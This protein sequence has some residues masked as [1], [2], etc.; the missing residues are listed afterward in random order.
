MRYLLTLLSITVILSCSHS[1]NEITKI[2]FARSG[3]WQDWGAAVSIDS[4]LTYQYY[5]G[6]Q[7]D[8]H[9][10]I[11][12]VSSEFW[13]TLNRKL[14]K[15]DLNNARS[16]DK[17]S[18]VDVHYYELI[19]YWH[20]NRK[21]FV[22]SSFIVTDSLS[23]FAAWINN[24]NKRVNLNIISKPINFETTFQNTPLLPNIKNIKFPPPIKL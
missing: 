9:Y 17:Q 5:G 19:T 11:G 14:A 16:E 21:R 6:K 4:T 2:E 20:G 22:R 1:R 15:I 3:A 10:Y 7:Q 23:H 13:D 24:S 12:K 8:R 18:V